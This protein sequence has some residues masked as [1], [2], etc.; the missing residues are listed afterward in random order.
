MKRFLMLLLLCA[1]AVS[2]CSS[3]KNR[4]G[5]QI[6]IDPSWYPL[7]VPGQEKNILAFSLE[8]LVEIAKK[9]HLQLAITSVNWNN[10]VQGLDEKKYDAILALLPRY[11][12]NLKM[13]SFS[14]PYLMTGPVLVVPAQSTIRSI[15]QLEGKEVG[16]VKGSSAAL[17]LQSAPGVI[18]RNYDSI[19]EA[20]VNLSDQQIEA[21]AVDTLIA[22]DYL[23]NFY[24]GSLK[25]LSPPLSDEGLRLITLHN[26]APKL[27]N[28]FNEGLAAFKKSGEY[29]KLLQK[30][31]LG[32]DGKP[33]AGLEQQ[34][35]TFLNQFL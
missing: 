34:I 31:G 28:R 23:R 33:V 16:I 26:A 27:I 13:Y 19:P 14:D 18:L 20:L 7:Q 3:K 10:L 30:W 25:M 29:D 2:G 24:Q 22:Q 8:L 4:S 17:L 6:G 21:A 5:Y 12:F 15:R 35:E 32:P 1:L 9:E 11:N